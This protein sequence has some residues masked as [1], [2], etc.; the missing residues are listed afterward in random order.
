MCQSATGEL[1]HTAAVA[2]EAAVC[3]PAV[4]VAVTDRTNVL[5]ASPF[6][7]V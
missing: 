2:A 4:F 1:V 5:P 7:S 3:E 6:V